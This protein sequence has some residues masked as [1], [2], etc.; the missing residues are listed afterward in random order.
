MVPIL[1]ILEDVWFNNSLSLDIS[2][3]TVF[4]L[5]YFPHILAASFATIQSFAYSSS[6]LWDLCVLCNLKTIL[7]FAKIVGMHSTYR[8]GHDDSMRWVSNAFGIFSWIF[9]E[10]YLSCGLIIPFPLS[11]NKLQGSWRFACEVP[12]FFIFFCTFLHFPF[13]LKN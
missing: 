13:Y 11:L 4:L 10:I 5:W 7:L 6:A 9:L 8:E 12:Q 1:K 3:Y 2:F